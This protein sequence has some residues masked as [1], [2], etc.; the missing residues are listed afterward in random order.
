VKTLVSPGVVGL[1]SAPARRRFADPTHSR[2][3]C[4]AAIYRDCTDD[5]AYLVFANGVTYRYDP[6]AGDV[7]VDITTATTHGRYFD[8]F[9]R[10]QPGDAGYERWTGGIP[11][12]AELIYSFPP[13]PGTDPGPCA[14]GIN[15]NDLVWDSPPDTNVE[16]GT[17]T[18][19]FSNFQ[20]AG[21]LDTNVPLPGISLAGFAN[22]GM[23][24]FVGPDQACSFEVD[25]FDYL[26]GDAPNTTLGQIV[27]QDGTFAN[28]ANFIMDG[29]T[30]PGHYS[31]PFTV[32]SG[33]I[34]PIFI[35][36]VTNRCIADSTPARLNFAFTVLPAM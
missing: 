6:S 31:F 3:P 32:P 9:A 30:P 24:T 10:R 12:T 7:S 16:I 26:P 20:N 11:G 29:S 34:Q 23:L 22:F 5:S 21:A 19:T 4:F 28:L 13:Y 15:F 35:G 36:Y 18:N 14:L 25:I 8:F 27:M 17:G 1:V 33:I 2:P